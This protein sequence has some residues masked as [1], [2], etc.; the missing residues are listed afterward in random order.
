[1]T[2]SAVGRVV[3]CKDHTGTGCPGLSLSVSCFFIRPVTPSPFPP[4]VEMEVNRDNIYSERSRAFHAERLLV[5]IFRDTVMG[6]VCPE[7]GFS[8]SPPHGDPRAALG[9]QPGFPRNSRWPCLLDSKG[10]GW[11]RWC[12]AQRLVR[13]C[14]LTPS[15]GAGVWSFVQCVKCP[16]SGPGAGDRAVSG[17]S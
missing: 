12:Q 17:W 5:A 6:R 4:Q 15:S 3:W 2:R 7:C 10:R 14:H 1:M 11:T 9:V 16:C 13:R 8:S